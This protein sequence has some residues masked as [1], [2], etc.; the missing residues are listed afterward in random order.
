MK[1]NRKSLTLALFAA[2]TLSLPFVAQADTSIDRVTIGIE[3][4]C[5]RGSNVFNIRNTGVVTSSA[6]RYRLVARASE[7]MPALYSWD[8]VLMPLRPSQTFRLYAPSVAFGLKLS[9]EVDAP[10]GTVVNGADTAIPYP[11]FCW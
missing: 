5:G 2:L 4:V 6:I 7:F 1:F 8:L 3:S 11:N 10:A 9:L